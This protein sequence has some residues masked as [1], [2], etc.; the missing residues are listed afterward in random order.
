MSTFRV[1][2]LP[3]HDL[4]RVRARGVDDFGNPVEVQ[5]AEED[6]A[7]PLRC[8]LRDAAV[9]EETALVAWRPASVGG[10]YAEVGPVFI[11]AEACAGY[12]DGDSYPAGFRRGASS[13][14][15]MT[16]PAARWT[17]G[18]SRGGTPRRR[19]PTSSP[20]R[21]STTCTAATC[22]PAA[23]CSRSRARSRRPAE[24]AAAYGNRYGYRY[25]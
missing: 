14:G 21:T 6:G 24:P 4:D 23:T 7:A 15:P 22:S 10:P 16:P 9:G 13:S 20:A 1:T 17:T 3:R 11:H 8:C 25:G 19:S 12:Q 5:V 2:A 18:S